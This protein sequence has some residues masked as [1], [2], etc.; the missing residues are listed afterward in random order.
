[1]VELGLDLGIAFDGDGDRVQFVDRK[2]R[3]FHGDH[4]LYLAALA[5]GEKGVVGTVMSNM[6]LEVA[7]KEKG[8]AFHRAAVG[9]RYV[10]ERLKETGLALGGS[11]R[12]T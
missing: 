5:F 6:G 8:L 2:G 3:L 7:L 4:I 10:L 1:M 12:G 9:D 11:L